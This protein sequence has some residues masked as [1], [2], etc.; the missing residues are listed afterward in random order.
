VPTVVDDIACTDPECS[1]RGVKGAGNVVLLWTYGP[2]AIR[3]LQCR[4]CKTR[5]SERRGT[6]LFDLR[7]PGMGLVVSL[8]LLDGAA[9]RE[10]AVAGQFPPIIEHRHADGAAGERR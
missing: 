5:F 10:A 2:D 1:K 9:S 6:P 7:V 4:E 8:Q 3:F